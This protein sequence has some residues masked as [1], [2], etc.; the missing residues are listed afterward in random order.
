MELRRK[1]AICTRKSRSHSLLS[2]LSGAKTLQ[3]A[4]QNALLFDLGRLEGRKMPFSEIHYD[5]LNM[6]IVYV[7]MDF[8]NFP[9]PQVRETVCRSWRRGHEHTMFIK[10]A[11]KGR[12]VLSHSLPS[13][14]KTFSQAHSLLRRDRKVK[15]WKRLKAFLH[16]FFENSGGRMLCK[17]KLILPQLMIEQIQ[18]FTAAAACVGGSLDQDFFARA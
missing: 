16:L 4:T 15:R 9:P 1:V 5:C 8:L 14:T 17:W 10:Y 11:I 6:I 12:P 7:K 2:I 3:I 18:L 13:P